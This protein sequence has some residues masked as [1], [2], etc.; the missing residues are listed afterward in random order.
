L[1][2][3]SQELENDIYTNIFSVPAPRLPTIKN[4]AIVRFSGYDT[5][6]GTWTCTKDSRST[7]CSHVV[8][9]RH[10]LQQHLQSNIHAIDPAAGSSDAQY[11]GKPIIDL[12]NMEAHAIIDSI[13]CP[14]S[15]SNNLSVSYW[16]IPPP[17]WA[18]IPSDPDAEYITPPGSRPE[19][20]NITPETS[21]CCCKKE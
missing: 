19:R 11:S 7:S 13:V 2:T 14:A 6:I 5:G 1:V 17:I 8:A 3:R 12:E 15:G 10:S 16:P 4:R 21:T 18:R 9:T 20:I